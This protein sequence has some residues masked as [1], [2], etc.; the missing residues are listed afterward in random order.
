[1]PKLSKKKAVG[2]AIEATQ[3]IIFIFNH[4]KLTIPQK[5]Y[6]SQVISKVFKNGYTNE[7]LRSLGFTYGD[8][9]G[10]EVTNDSLAS[11]TQRGR[12]RACYGRRP[13][14]NTRTS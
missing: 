10:R 12:D 6:A 13:K 1:M 4:R 14:R 9:I 11:K 5:R 7:S 8:V 3:N 2:A